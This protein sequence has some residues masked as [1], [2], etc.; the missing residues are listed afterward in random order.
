MQRH[1]RTLKTDAV[2]HRMVINNEAQH[3]AIRPRIWDQWCSEATSTAS[4]H[5]NLLLDCYLCIGASCEVRLPPT[6]ADRADAFEFGLGLLEA[7]AAMSASAE[8]VSRP[9]WPH[10]NLVESTQTLLAEHKMHRDSDARVQ[11]ALAK[12]QLS[13][14]Q[15]T[16]R[17]LLRPPLH[18]RLC[19]G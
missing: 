10:D 2:T 11:A 5:L 12:Q 16:L 17:A 15:R 1:S 13:V 7:E 9:A 14:L 3:C 6:A 4:G 19:C 8:S 18:H